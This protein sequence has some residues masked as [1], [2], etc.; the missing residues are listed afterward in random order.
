MISFPH[1]MLHF[2]SELLRKLCLATH[3]EWAWS[4]C[5]GEHSCIPWGRY[6]SFCVSLCTNYACLGSLQY[7]LG[8]IGKC[9]T[10]AR[11]NPRA[12]VFSQGQNYNLMHLLTM[13]HNPWATATFKHQKS[14]VTDH[15]NGHHR[16][17]YIRWRHGITC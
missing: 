14:A 6:V 17:Q 12:T 7:W 4:F 11:I 2:L 3:Q 8:Y 1:T 13:C 10:N 15:S 9:E 16:H 5:T